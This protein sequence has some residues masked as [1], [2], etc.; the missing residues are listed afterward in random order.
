MLSDRML[1]AIPKKGRLYEAVVQLL[2]G[3]DINFVKK[4]RLDIA[5]VSNFPIAI[6]FLPA[7]DIPKFVAEGNVDIGITGQDMISEAG[8]NVESLLELEFGKCNLCVQVPID[9]EIKNVDQLI[10]KRIATS[11]ESITKKYFNRTDE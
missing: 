2:H 11:F 1:F 5:N 9:G 10:G 4:Q 6:V 8:V 3:A 7:A